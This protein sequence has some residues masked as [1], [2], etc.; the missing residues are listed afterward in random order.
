M[1]L[2]LSGTML[3]QLEFPQKHSQI[4][5]EGPAAGGPPPGPSDGRPR[6]PRTS[7]GR[8]RARARGGLP[9]CCDSPIPPLAL[10][11]KSRQK[12]FSAL[13]ASLPYL[14]RAPILVRAPLFKPMPKKKFSRCA[15]APSSNPRPLFVPNRIFLGHR[16]EERSTNE[17]GSPG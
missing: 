6:G 5:S 9:M 17:D 7:W 15:R 3:G 1:V 14:P 11:F 12:K 8:A 2:T 10:L 16:F 4:F 13:R